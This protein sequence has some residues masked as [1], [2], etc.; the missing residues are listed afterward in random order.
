MRKRLIL[1]AILF[2]LL[3]FLS[4]HFIL[5]K[6]WYKSLFAATFSSFFWTIGMYFF[7]KWWKK[8][9]EEQKSRRV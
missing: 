7:L 9:A 8:K 4:H 5:G 1:A 3:T 2:F 6:D